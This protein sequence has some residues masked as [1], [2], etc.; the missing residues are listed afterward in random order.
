MESNNNQKQEVETESIVKN[1][2]ENWG[3]N[4]DRGYHR[5]YAGAL[6]ISV[7]IQAF[8]IPL[9]I[10]FALG[11]L[12]SKIIEESGMV[13]F[14]AFVGYLVTAFI[15][16]FSLSYKVKVFDNLSKLAQNSEEILKKLEKREKI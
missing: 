16:W 13:V 14:L 4:A 12:L 2:Y 8:V 10:W 3:F 6:K 7:F 1:T 9:V 11:F 5:G 15:L